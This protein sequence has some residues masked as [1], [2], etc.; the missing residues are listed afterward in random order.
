MLFHWIRCNIYDDLI[1]HWRR[2]GGYRSYL[3]LILTF[4]ST[5][6]RIYETREKQQMIQFPSI[7]IVLLVVHGRVS[8]VGKGE[9]T[10][11]NKN[12]HK[13]LDRRSN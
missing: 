3:T 7:G 1:K 8:Q 5:F 4:H 2:V 10:A 9:K 13:N 11:K 6:I 12:T